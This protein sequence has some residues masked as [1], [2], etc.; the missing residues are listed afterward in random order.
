[1][2]IN[3][4]I[5]KST[6]RTAILAA[7]AISG[8]ATDAFAYDVD[9]RSRET[10]PKEMHASPKCQQYYYYGKKEKD[11]GHLANAEKYL[12][13][14]LKDASASRNEQA[15]D[16]ICVPMTELQNRYA[17]AKKYDRSEALMKY[18]LQV[19]EGFKGQKSPKLAP[20]LQMLSVAL[21]QQ[22]KTAEAQKIDERLSSL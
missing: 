9:A 1:M 12:M 2:L 13:A 17:S 16:W 11:A 6:V 10:I 21:K 4:S 18:V 5:A 22:G 20:Y 19:Q 3:R 8:L 7:L 14:A 15:S